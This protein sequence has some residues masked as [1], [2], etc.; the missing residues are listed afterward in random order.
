MAFAQGV[1]A[2][3]MFATVAVAAASPVWADLADQTSGTYTAQSPNDPQISTWTITPCG[4]TCVNVTS[5][6]FRG[7]RQAQLSSKTE[8]WTFSLDQVIC[9]D[10]SSV[11]GRTTYAWLPYSL[12][13]TRTRSSNGIPACGNVSPIDDVTTLILTRLS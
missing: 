6:L 3:A 11:P 7:T 8:E 4:S 10:G 1:A 9:P 5:G 13:G 2:T 12:N